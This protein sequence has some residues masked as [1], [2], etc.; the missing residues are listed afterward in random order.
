M[1]KKNQGMELLLDFLPELVTAIPDIKIEVIGSGPDEEYF[2]TMAGK[3]LESHHV[4]FHG[5]ISDE[6]EM[7]GSS[8]EIS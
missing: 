4:I 3:S 6:K 2:E 8:M 7:K 1:L 5:L